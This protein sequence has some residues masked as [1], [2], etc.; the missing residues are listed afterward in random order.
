MTFFESIRKCVVIEA[1]RCDAV[2]VYILHLALRSTCRLAYVLEC[3]DEAWT[4]IRHDVGKFLSMLYNSG[5][6]THG[7]VEYT[8]VAK[9]HPVNLCQ[10][11]S[12]DN[13]LPVHLPKLIAFTDT[14]FASG[15]YL[16]VKVFFCFY[17][18][19]LFS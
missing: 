6:S 7:I 4:G 8:H 15:K 16:M 2:T 5:S 11:H 18:I 12:V 10:Y 1:K 3:I 13:L 19:L 14:T 9:T 17:S